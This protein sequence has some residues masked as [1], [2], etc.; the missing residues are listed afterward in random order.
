MTLFILLLIPL[1]IYEVRVLMNPYEHNRMV[2]DIFHIIKFGDVKQ[3]MTRKQLRFILFQYFYL[4]MMI[5]TLF[6]DVWLM[7]LIMIILSRTTYLLRKYL[8]KDDSDDVSD[9]IISLI[10]TDS[11]VSLTVL[12]S[13]ILEYLL[14]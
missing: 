7:G 12:V 6:T 14:V 3:D 13:G 1:I 11:I 10:R 9:S 2:D 4:I 8:K 5:I